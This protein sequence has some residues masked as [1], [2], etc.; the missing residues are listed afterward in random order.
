M[1]NNSILTPTGW[2]R[3]LVGMDQVSGVLDRPKAYYNI[4]GVGELGIGFMCVCFALL[5]WMQV[6]SSEHSAWNRPYTLLVFMAV[7]CSIIHYGS[8]AIKK[9]ITYPRTGFVQYSRRDTVWRPAVLCFRS[10]EDQ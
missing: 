4:D 6:R 1:S 9:H 5:G 3:K 7:V 10:G 8:K 2:Q